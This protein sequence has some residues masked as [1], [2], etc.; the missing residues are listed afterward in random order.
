MYAVHKCPFYWG[1]RQVEFKVPLYWL[2][3]H[4][5]LLITFYLQIRVL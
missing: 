4:L 3:I 5:V 2:K 1:P